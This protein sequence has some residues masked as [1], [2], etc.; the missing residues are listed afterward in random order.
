M[1]VKYKVIEKGQP[2]VL[3]GGTKLNYASLVSG[4]E[5]TLEDLSKILEKRSTISGA[6]LRAVVYGIVDA[7]RDALEDGKIVR[8]GDLGS[9]RMS[10][11]SKGE[12]TAEDVSITT[13]DGV[14]FIFTPG[15]L[16]KD[17]VKLLKYTKV[18]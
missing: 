4:G 16:L 9:L 11:K 1:P 7:V 15:P 17:M 10:L 18:S 13:I 12:A 3:G 14:K 2:G 8:L 5:M 6:D